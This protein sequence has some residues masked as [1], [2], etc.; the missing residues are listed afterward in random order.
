[1]SDRETTRALIAVAVIVWGVGILLSVLAGSAWLLTS[2]FDFPAGAAPVEHL[3]AGE[4]PNW[5]EIT[6][7]IATVVLTIATGALALAAFRALGGLKESRRDRHV[8]AMADMSRS[9]DDE[10]FRSVRHK[11]QNYAGSGASS[12]NSLKDRLVQLRESNDPG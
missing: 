7:A 1:V 12:R 9:W 8:A 5:A 2:D 3:S 4:G 11:I 10:H 6:L